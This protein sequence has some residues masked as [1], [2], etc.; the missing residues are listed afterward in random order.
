MTVGS[1]LDVQMPIPSNKLNKL[2]IPIIR[3]EL[4]PDELTLTHEDETENPSWV[5]VEPEFNNDC[6]VVVAN[7]AEK[8]DTSSTAEEFGPDEL[9]LAHECET[10]NSSRVP[11]EPEFNS[12]RLAVLF[13]DAEKFDTLL[14]AEECVHDLLKRKCQEQGVMIHKSELHA[15]AKKVSLVY[16][17][18]GGS[19]AGPFEKLALYFES[20]SAA[21]LAKGLIDK[22][23]KAKAV[24]AIANKKGKKEKN[25][26]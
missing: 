19:K 15:E 3:Y 21:H 18:D 5:P 10:E 7:D 16:M 20:E 25:R 11:V 2:D 8:L 14:A 22:F 9:T 23:L 26:H 24:S 17:Q 1:R 12:D 4:V 6:S 13:D